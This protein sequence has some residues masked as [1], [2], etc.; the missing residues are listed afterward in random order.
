IETVLGGPDPKKKAKEI[1]F[2]LTARLRKHMGNPTFRALS[3]RLEALRERHEQGQLTSV[4]FLKQL[5]DLSRDTVA[6]E[7]DAPPEADEDRGKAKL[8]ELFNQ[9][10][11]QKTPVI[12][13]RIVADIDAIVR[14]VR[15]ANWQHT[16][17]GERDVKRALR[18]TL[19]KYKLH[20]DR[21]LFEKAYGYVR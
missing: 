1:E 18:Q 5:L 19:L 17:A 15:F 13:E 6:A 9:V 16:A 20:D 2:K 14:A 4:E 12:V 21:E 7:R 8:T 10:R 3:E 11:N